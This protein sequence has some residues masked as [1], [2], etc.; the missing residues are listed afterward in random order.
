MA[1]GSTT[2]T[3]NGHRFAIVTKAGQRRSAYYRIGEDTNSSGYRLRGQRL[4]VIGRSG[5]RIY[6]E[7]M[8]RALPF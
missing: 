7:N 1:S 3:I 8:T 2:V 6:T 4:R 5:N